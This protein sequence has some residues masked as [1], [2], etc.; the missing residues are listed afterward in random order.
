MGIFGKEELPYGFITVETPEGHHM[1]IKVDAYTVYE[2][3]NI[4]DYVRIDVHRL[5]NTEILV[6]REIV[7]AAPFVRATT[8]EAKT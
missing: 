7:S 8:V 6:A 1:T 5:A 2:T 3:L 4:G